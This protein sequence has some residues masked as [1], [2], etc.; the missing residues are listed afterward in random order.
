MD[1]TRCQTKHLEMASPLDFDS[2]IDGL[3]AVINTTSAVHILGLCILYHVLVALYN[4]S[5]LHPLSR[6]PGPKLAAMT[7]AYEAYFDLIKVGR[8]SWEIKRMHENYGQ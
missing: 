4:I 8:Y 1:W 5:P 7:I 3:K 2:G 6:I